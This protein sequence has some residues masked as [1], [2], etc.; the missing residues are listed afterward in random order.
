MQVLYVF[1]GTNRKIHPNKIESISEFNLPVKIQNSIQKSITDNR[2]LWEAWAESSDSFQDL[3]ESL[4]KR[5]YKNLPI[6]SFPKF[7]ESISSKISFGKKEQGRDFNFRNLKETKTM[8]R[9]KK[10]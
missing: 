2:M 8:L 4:K 10:N 6:S 3:K 1:Q 7:K 9:R 5:G